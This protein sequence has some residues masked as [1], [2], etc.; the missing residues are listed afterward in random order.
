MPFTWLIIDVDS[1]ASLDV[2][3]NKFHTTLYVQNADTS[4]TTNRYLFGTSPFSLSGSK[5]NRTT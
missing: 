2:A 5:I 3:P 4:R 1:V